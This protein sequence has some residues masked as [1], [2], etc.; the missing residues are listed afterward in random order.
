MLFQSS[1]QDALALDG[2]K[3]ESESGLVTSMSVAMSNPQRKK[4]RTDAGTHKREVHISNLPRS[5]TKQELEELFGQVRIVP[6][7]F[8]IRPLI[9]LLRLDLFVMFAS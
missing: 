3:S 8:C 5:M 6:G 7:V 1:A 9:W 2:W 4:E